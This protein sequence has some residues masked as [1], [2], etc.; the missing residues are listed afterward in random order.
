MMEWRRGGWG[1]RQTRSE[2]TVMKEDFGCAQ[3]ARATQQLCSVTSQCHYVGPRYSKEDNVEKAAVER[4]GNITM[5][6]KNRG[7]SWWHRDYVM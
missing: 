2:K 3:R 5:P 6:R 7:K 4:A 1:G